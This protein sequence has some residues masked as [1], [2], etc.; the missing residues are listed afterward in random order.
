[1]RGTQINKIDEI[2]KRQAQKDKPI[3]ISEM[4]LKKDDKQIMVK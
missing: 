4:T 1:M 2:N 3:E